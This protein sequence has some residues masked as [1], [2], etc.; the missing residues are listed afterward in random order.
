MRISC[1][2]AVLGEARGVGSHCVEVAGGEILG[3]GPGELQ[4]AGNDPFKPID[5]VDQMVEARFAHAQPAPPELGN[6]TNA[7]QGVS[8][9]MGHPGQELSESRQA[10]APPQLGAEPLA[11]RGLAADD[12]RQ[13][14]GEDERRARSR[15]EPGPRT[16]GS[17]ERIRRCRLDRQAAS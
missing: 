7:R 10:L 1:A 17:P 12:P 13:A 11:F 4:E 2:G 6:G 8:D 14:D 16:I 9:L 5:L 15:P 3:V